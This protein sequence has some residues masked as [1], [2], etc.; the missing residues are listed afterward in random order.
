MN[1]TRSRRFRAL[2]GGIAR[3]TL[4]GILLFVIIVL[5]TSFGMTLARGGGTQ[6]L[7]T[8]LPQLQEDLSELLYTVFGA[9]SEVVREM[10][11]ALPRSIVLLS[12]STTLGA[13]IGVALGGLAAVRRGSKVAAFLTTA[14]VLGISTPSYIV[15]MVLIWTVVWGYQAFDIRLL[16]VFGFGWDEH[17]IMPLVVLASRPAAHMMRLAQAS[18]VDVFETDYVRTARGKGLRPRTVFWKHVLRNA[19]VPLLTSAVVSLRFSLST[20]PVVEYIFSWPGLGLSLLQAVQALD[21]VT[22]VVMVLPLVI[23]FI[24]INLT[25]GMFYGLIDRRLIEEDIPL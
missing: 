16:P 14:S 2:A 24:G 9:D 10:G 17:L 7:P 13:A 21:L 15:A 22:V 19:G 20:L 4:G 5:L 3:R 1:S 25:L 12:I 11:Q 6:S 8:A 23:L 18:L